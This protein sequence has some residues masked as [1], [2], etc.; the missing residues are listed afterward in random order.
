MPEPT[1]PH[2]DP[3]HTGPIPDRHTVRRSEFWMSVMV[4]LFVVEFFITI[5]AL[6]Y[7]IVMT[8]PRRQGEIMRLAFPWI[9]WFAAMLMAPALIISL[10]RMFAGKDAH[11]EQRAERE[12]AWANRL[13]ERA[14][15]LYRC[16][17][18]APL[19]VLSL[20]LVALGA[21][22]LTIDS[23]LSLLGDIA[24]ALVPY[25]PY[26]IGA[27][28][29]FAVAIA[30][31][32]AWFRYKHNQLLADYQFR[33]E[34]LEKTGIILVDGKGKAIMPAAGDGGYALG[35]LDAAPGDNGLIKALPV[36]PD[37]P[38]SPE[39]PAD[40]PLKPGDSPQQD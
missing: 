14:L 13:P 6:C 36:A 27:V 34:V 2:S 15:R 21:T 8:P 31:L 40:N 10:A 32:M 18:D 11:D 20:A 22:L 23:A 26:F 5:V 17:K 24:Q 1:P 33:R 9:G 3:A 12:A 35:Q 25:A 38:L 7:G 30:A 4:L 19:F 39:L 16:I 29:A 37:Q 28:T